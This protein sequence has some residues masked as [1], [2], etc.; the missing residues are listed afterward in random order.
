[1]AIQS[2]N[3][4]ALERKKERKEEGKKVRQTEHDD[5]IE[6]MKMLVSIDK[7]PTYALWYIAIRWRWTAHMLLTPGDHVSAILLTS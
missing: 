4:L 7:T 3:V 6:S 2:I 1:L 5:L